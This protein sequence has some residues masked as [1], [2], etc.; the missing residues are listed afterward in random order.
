MPKPEERYQDLFSPKEQMEFAVDAV[1]K[2][3]G[4]T[5]HFNVVY[6]TEADAH[7][8]FLSARDVIRERSAEDGSQTVYIDISGDRL[9]EIATDPA[10]AHLRTLGI[11]N[12]ATLLYAGVLFDYHDLLGLS[13]DELTSELKEQGTVLT[14][15]LNLITSLADAKG[16]NIDFLEIC[17]VLPQ[18]LE[19]AEQLGLNTQGFTYTIFRGIDNELADQVFHVLAF[20][21]PLDLTEKKIRHNQSVNG[22]A[23]DVASFLLKRDIEQILRKRL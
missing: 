7:Q 18:T 11:T 13:I 14:A 9:E 12:A 1:Q 20:S 19:K 16:R 5:K 4:G 15:I 6:D 3:L 2:S 8:A 21:E 23:N 10:Y 22:Y 17:D